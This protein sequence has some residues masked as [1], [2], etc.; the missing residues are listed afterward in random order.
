MS[1]SATPLERGDAGPGPARS[2]CARGGQTDDG[3]RRCWPDTAAPTGRPR[4]SSLPSHE[5][6]ALIGILRR[7]L[8]P[9]TLTDLDEVSC[10][11]VLDQLDSKEIAGRG[12]AQLETD[13]A[14]EILADLDESEQAARSWPRC[15]CPSAQAI[16][17]GLA[18][19]GMERR[20]PDAARGGRGARST[21]RVGQAIDYLRAQAPTCRTTS[22]TSSW[23]TRA[24]RSSATCRSAACCAASGRCR[25]STS[26]TRICAPSA[27]RGRP[28]G[29]GARLPPLRPGLRPGGR[30][31]RPAA[32]RD[33]RRRR[34][35]R[36]RRG[37]RGRHPQAGRRRRATTPTSRP[38]RP[39]SSG[40]PGWASTCSRPCWAPSSSPSSRARSRSWSRSPP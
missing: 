15:R 9:E 4:S 12:A 33:H 40:C 23:S 25:W 18:Y 26:S 7:D 29:G 31:R 11:D 37:G 6:D 24:S 28:G 32:R 10:D 30:R 8:D 27:G 22:T 16:E 14:V 2:R 38:C 21:G 39:A 17:Q 3:Q 13:D 1:A 5:R 20:P 36:D 19:P 35:R 34:G